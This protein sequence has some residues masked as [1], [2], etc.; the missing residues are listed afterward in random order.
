MLKD[1]LTSLVYATVSTVLLGAA[2]VFGAQAPLATASPAAVI[3]D[4]TQPNTP[5]PTTQPNTPTPTTPV[6]TPT[7]P[8]ETPTPV[9]EVPTEE[10]PPDR[11]AD[12]AVSKEAAQD[13]V[14]LGDE[15]TYNIVVTNE[16]NAL[17]TGVIV[18]DTLPGYLQLLSASVD[19]GQAV[20]N[21]NTAGF[22]IGDVEPGEVV[23]GTITARVVA[24]PP[25]GV[26]ENEAVLRSNNGSDRPRNNRSSARVRVRQPAETPTPTALPGELTPTPTPTPDPLTPQPTQP[27]PSTL[28][29]TADAGDLPLGVLALVALAATG[30]IAAGVHFWR[31]PRR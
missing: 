6:E 25:D 24:L 17:A 20:I 8:V 4:T 7:T 27:A 16:G 31:R 30:Y 15:I 13:E 23:R 9:T 19:K 14:G 18:E 2:L 22:W 26:I 1:R 28:P 10:P 12:P 21:G 5:T 29:V 11:Y 3:T